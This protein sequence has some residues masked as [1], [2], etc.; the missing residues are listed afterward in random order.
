V[1][2][3]AHPFAIHKQVSILFTFCQIIILVGIK[4]RGAIFTTST[5]RFWS[6]FTTISARLSPNTISPNRRT[7]SQINQFFYFLTSIVMGA[8]NSAVVFWK[9]VPV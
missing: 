6:I 3:I 1:P 8:K 4:A 7:I 9:I 2:I 5:I